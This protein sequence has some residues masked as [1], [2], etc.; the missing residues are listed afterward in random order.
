MNHLKLLLAAAALA[1]PA[2]LAAQ[3]GPQAPQAETDPVWRTM[4]AVESRVSPPVFP[5]RTFRIADYHR[6]ADS[7]YTD[8]I[9]R[10]IA[11]C[12]AQGGGTVEIPDGDWHTG[13]IRLRSNVNLHLADRARLLF[14]TDA[15]LFPVVMTRIEGVDC[16]NLSPLVYAFGE[17]NIAITGRGIL[18]GQADST[19]WLSRPRIHGVTTPEGKKIKEKTRFYEMF[20]SGTPVR[21]RVFAG[22][23]GMRPQ[24]VCLYRCHNIL[25]EDFTVHR[26]PFWILHP[27]FSDNITVRRCRLESHGSNND[28]CDPESCRDVIIDDCDFDTGDDCIAIKSG[29]DADGRRWMTPS[30]NIIVRNC[31]MRDGHA[32]VAIG[33]EI[34]GGCRNVWVENCHMDSPNLQRVIRI[35]SNPNRGG[36]V[37]GV[38][39]RNIEVGQCA[40]AVLGFELQ[41][42]RV[43]DGPY[44]PYFHDIRLSGITSKGS[45]YLMKLEGIEG[46][47]LA[48]DISFTDCHFS[49]VREK[50]INLVRGV[51]AI[52][53]SGCT[54][55]GKPYAY[56]PTRRK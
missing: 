19:N 28:G 22:E 6:A 27:L 10:A 54:L 13:P 46:K 7:L 9:N 18:D 4:R 1:A 44:M 3:R 34:T 41:Y 8:A 11:D 30:E 12:S 31:R 32:G 23:E 15:K 14:T 29:K 17:T 42:W 5:D 47:A 50:D 40:E 51:E 36:E 21:E 37:A 25:L 49:G 35:K 16:Y 48:R 45:R 38:Y 33:S 20:E 55:D 39:V 56:R 53:F 24:T 52:T 26:S 43:Y 2:A